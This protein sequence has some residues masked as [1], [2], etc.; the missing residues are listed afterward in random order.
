[1]KMDENKPELILHAYYYGFNE[2]GIREI[3]LI[4]AAVAAAGK[5][6]HHTEAWNEETPAWRPGIVGNSPI[7]WIQNAANNAAEHLKQIAHDARREALAEAK[8][9]VDNLLKDYQRDD[10]FSL[11][12]GCIEAIAAIKALYRGKNEI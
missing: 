1:M 9:A 4:L 2:T 5:A 6:Y 3:D 11:A 8:S 12:D 7:E 10:M